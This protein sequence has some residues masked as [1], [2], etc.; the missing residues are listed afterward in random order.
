MKI[1][2]IRIRDFKSIYGEQYFDFESLDGLIKLSGIIGAG[3]TTVGEA[4]LWGYRSR[5]NK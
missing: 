3:K 2:N 4:I 1:K 5:N